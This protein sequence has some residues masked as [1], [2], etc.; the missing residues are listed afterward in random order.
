MAERPSHLLDPMLFAIALAALLI[1][2]ASAPSFVSLPDDR[3][4]IARY[5]AQLREVGQLVFN[6]GEP[7][8]LIAA[9]LPMVAQALLGAELL[10]ALSMALGA[11]CLYQL[12]AYTALTSAFRLLAAGMFALAYPLWI[13]AGSPYP[14]MTAL[15]LLGLLLAQQGHWR[16]SGVAFGLAALC[17]VEAL[18]LATLMALR[19]T[20]QG[21]ALRFTLS[22]AALLG[23]ALAALWL[24]YLDASA[25]EGLFVF[26][27]SASLAEDLF[28]APILILLVA[29]ALPMWWQARRE[30]FIALLGAWIALYGG[31]L[32]GILRLEGSYTYA[33][34]VPAAAILAARLFQRA[35]IVSVLGIGVTVIACIAVLSRAN[36]PIEAPERPL[37]SFEMRSVAVPSKDALLR[38]AWRLDQEL[39]TLDG[40]LQPELRQMIERGDLH[41]ALV[42]YAPDML[43]LAHADDDWRYTDAFAALGYAPHSSEPE[44]TFQRTTDVAPFSGRFYAPDQALSADLRLRTIALAVPHD[45]DQPVVRLCLRWQVERPASRPIV[46]EIALGSVAQRTEFAAAIFSAG[47]FDTYHAL[48]VPAE[49]LKGSVPLRVR[50]IVNNGT[51]GE[52]SLPSVD[53][54]GVS[55]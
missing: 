29:A 13:G 2:V 53:L 46:V 17:G 32:G 10:F 55:D 45:A 21:K 37:A 15:A 52:V 3:L 14:P 41:S 12:T 44:R 6:R 4:I 27:R 47:E 48:S 22:F 31:I 39:I 54:S 25:L 9:P 36:A 11:A 26:K 34:I 42:R 33:P 28:A 24:H 50:V 8:L 23:A 30:P 18:V 35:P 43:V 16:W 51:L 19:A 38:Q 7:S 1:G 40:T 49:M 5:A 20:Q